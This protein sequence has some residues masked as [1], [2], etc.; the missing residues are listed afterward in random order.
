MTPEFLAC[1]TK[2]VVGDITFLNNE[3]MT[4]NPGREA[5]SG[6]GWVGWGQCRGGYIMR[7]FLEILLLRG[8]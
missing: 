8:F 7:S 2:W 6:R 3:D 5:G 4:T 1:K